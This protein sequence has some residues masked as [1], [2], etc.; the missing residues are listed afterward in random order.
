MNK[1]YLLIGG[2]LGDRS[3]NLENAFSMI[4]KEAG[5]IVKH[6]FR[7]ETPPWGPVQQPYFLN[8]C[9]EL[10]TELSPMDLLEVLL[11]IEKRLGRVRTVKLGPRLI[12]IDILLYND[13][14]LRHPALSIPHPE[15]ANRRFALVPLNEIAP[16]RLHPVRKKTI[17]RLLKECK[18]RTAVQL[19][20]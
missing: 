7:Y 3:A 1:A 14:V 9:L 8:Q 4:D 17:S 10:E 19:R 15:L 13:L 2:N 12:D 18:D 20:F 11:A 5:K 16:D 6:S